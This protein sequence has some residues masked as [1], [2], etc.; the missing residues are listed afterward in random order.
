ML[1]S[2]V[3]PSYTV[4]PSPYLRGDGAAAAYVGMRDPQGRA[5]R[6]WAKEVRLAVSIVANV[7]TYRKTDIDRKWLRHADNQASIS[8]DLR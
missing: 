3:K 2:I 6:K 1:L 7:R 5:F 8:V 4:G